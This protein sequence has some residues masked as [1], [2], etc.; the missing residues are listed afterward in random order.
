MASHTFM[1]LFTW[2]F[3]QDIFSA[4][5][6]YFSISK[7]HF[8]S[9]KGISEQLQIIFNTGRTD[10]SK[11]IIHKQNVCL[12]TLKLPH[13]SSCFCFVCSEHLYREK[14]KKKQKTTSPACFR[15]PWSS[16][17]SFLDPSVDHAGLLIW[18]SVFGKRYSPDRAQ[19][20]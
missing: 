4:A 1:M 19:C 7:L 13:K 12:F 10:S 16:Q 6:E 17:I 3:N 11:Q 14:K 2:Y 20:H 9:E 15:K 8:D 18:P 5:A